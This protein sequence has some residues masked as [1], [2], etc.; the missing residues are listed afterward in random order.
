M[1]EDR[2]ASCVYLGGKQRV[3]KAYARLTRAWIE[4]VDSGP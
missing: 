3:A 4:P 2:A 1:P